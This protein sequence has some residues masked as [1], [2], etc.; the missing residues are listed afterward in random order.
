M[1]FEAILGPEL[2]D[3]GGKPVA[4]ADKLKDQ[5]RALKLE[6]KKIQQEVRAEKQELK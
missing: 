4:T 5:M 3:A 6:K 1:S 2:L